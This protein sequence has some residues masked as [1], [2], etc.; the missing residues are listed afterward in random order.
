MLL[1]RELHPIPG[2]NFSTIY[3][4]FK[5]NDCS[6]FVFVFGTFFK[7][8]IRPKTPEHPEGEKRYSSDERRRHFERMYRDEPAERPL[9][10]TDARVRYSYYK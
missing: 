5:L 1:D 2:G 4:L 10:W 3:L 7:S 8:K 6:N 9:D